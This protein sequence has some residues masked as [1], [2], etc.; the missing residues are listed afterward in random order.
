MS[1]NVKA[2]LVLHEPNRWRGLAQVLQLQFLE[3]QVFLE[4]SPDG[5]FDAEA[6]GASPGAEPAGCRRRWPS[7]C[8]WTPMAG[9]QQQRSEYPEVLWLKGV[10]GPT[11][12]SLHVFFTC[13][14]GYVV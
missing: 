4:L 9:C 2:L 10:D 1:Y 14:F 6:P 7:S 12:G 13:G 5:L 3:V 8:R 11:C